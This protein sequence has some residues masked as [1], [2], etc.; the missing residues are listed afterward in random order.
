PAGDIVVVDTV[1]PPA[2]TPQQN[3]Q[4]QT[5]T[6]TTT[7]TQ[8]PDGS[9]TET[10]TTTKADGSTTVITT[11]TNPDGSSTTTTTTTPGAGSSTS[12]GGGGGSGNGNG[13]GSEG[14]EQVDICKS[15][16]N[17]PACK[18]TDA[19][20]AAST[21]GLYEVDPARK[22]FGTILEG[23]AGK[24]TQLGWY[25]S[26]SGFFN[27]Q[28]PSGSCGGM[29]GSVGFGGYSFEYDL[30][31]IFCGSAA[32]TMYSI[33]SIGVQ[34]AATWIAFSIAFL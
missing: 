18:E 29:S 9:T 1:P 3:T 19:G 15:N 10:E 7:T 16:P 20:D 5:T 12:S 24:V 17:I 34:L 28:V 21:D 13:N 6:T 22:T 30:D 32:Q 2:S 23:F 27:V 33:L 31:P 25:Q 26:V 11:T 8:N 4:Q 14:N